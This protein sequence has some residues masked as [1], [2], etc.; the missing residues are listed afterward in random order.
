MTVSISRKVVYAAMSVVLLTGSLMASSPKS[1]PDTVAVQAT[2]WNF[3]KE[4]SDLLEETRLLSSKLRVDADQLESYTGSKLSW[5]SHGDQLTLVKD[6]INQM[7][8]RLERLQEIRHV[9]SPWQQQAIDRMVPVAVE[10]ATRT[11]AAIEHLNENQS[12]LF[13]P[14]YTGHLSTIAEQAGTLNE[15]ANTFVEYGKIQEKLDQL[16]EKLEIRAS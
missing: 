13:A 1:P 8:G 10:L 5:Q 6:H 2:A 7:G 16:R 4:A 9:A 15:S 3:Q 11:Q 14:T 12:Y